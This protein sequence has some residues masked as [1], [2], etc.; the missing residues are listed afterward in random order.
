[1]KLA[2][3]GTIALDRPVILLDKPFNNLDI[4]T[5]QLIASLLKYWF[6]SRNR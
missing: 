4:E 5:N 2:L 1:M 3:I 6:N